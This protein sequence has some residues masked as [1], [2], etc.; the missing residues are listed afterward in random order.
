[1]RG[2]ALCALALLA[3]CEGCK[4]RE[5][6]AQ[7]A[8]VQVQEIPLA[9]YYPLRPGNRWRYAVGD[10]RV[11]SGVSGIDA[12][13]IAVIIDDA[14]SPITRVRVTD[15]R[16]EITSPDGQALTPL[17][18]APLRTGVTWT[19]A[20]DATTRCDARVLR[21]DATITAAEV[22]LA[23]CAEIETRCALGASG[24]RAATLHVRTDT[25]CPD[26]GRVRMISRFDP[27]RPEAPSET[28]S[29]LVAWR[30]AG[31]PLPPRGADVCNEVI[32]LP[33]DLAAACVDMEPD[34]PFASSA[35]GA[36]AYG[37]H[38]TESFARV[39]ATRGEPH[40][41]DVAAEVQRQV[42]ASGVTFALSAKGPTC[43][44][45]ALARLDPLLRSLVAR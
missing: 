30:V 9:R 32:L 19:F 43:T 38:G 17:L 12:Q 35:N 45:A 36:C 40:P 37:M 33:S 24:E 28:R 42:L 25:Y 4:A 1:M 2:L 34:V 31:G 41:V 3:S 5:A 22:A 39:I 10:T 8:P 16:I 23:S 18:V 13:G 26:V 14:R 44:D 27:P 21:T 15:T 29:E 6:P 7:V 20:P 11:A